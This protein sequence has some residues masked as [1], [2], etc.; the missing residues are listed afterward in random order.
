MPYTKEQFKEKYGVKE[1]I[2]AE[3][4]AYNKKNELTPA[5]TRKK[6]RKALKEALDEVT[7]TA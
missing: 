7:K 6:L 4:D 2:S 1:M 5:S 3:I